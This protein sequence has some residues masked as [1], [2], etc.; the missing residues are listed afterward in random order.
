M[1]LMFNT[2]KPFRRLKTRD[3]MLDISYPA[4]FFFLELIFL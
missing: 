2:L 3:D 1:E 4:F